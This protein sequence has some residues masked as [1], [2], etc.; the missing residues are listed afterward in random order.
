MN[1]PP[2]TGISRES[3]SVMFRTGPGP[4]RAAAR[5]AALRSASAARAW[6]ASTLAWASLTRQW[7]STPAASG[8]AARPRRGCPAAYRSSSSAS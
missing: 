5:S 2:R 8:R 4:L 1:P 6:A 7:S 3:G